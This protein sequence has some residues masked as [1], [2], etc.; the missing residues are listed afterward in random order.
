MKEFITNLLTIRCTSQ[1]DGFLK[2]KLFGYIRKSQCKE[3]S[4]TSERTLQ[5]PSAI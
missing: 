4:R 3:M 1:M 2:L 5:M